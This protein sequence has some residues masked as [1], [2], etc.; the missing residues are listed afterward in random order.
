MSAMIPS[1]H[2]ITLPALFGWTPALLISKP[3]AASA[4][5][6]A[7]FLRSDGWNAAFE[8]LTPE[9]HP[10]RLEP[11]LL[12][13][14]YSE[15]DLGQEW[16]PTCQDA[17]TLGL[18]RRATWQGQHVLR[19]PSSRTQDATRLPSPA[20]APSGGG[21]AA[22][23]DR[24]RRRDLVPV[25]SAAACGR[26]G[27]PLPRP[28]TSPRP[29]WSAVASSA[30]GRTPL[31]P[32]RNPCLRCRPT[33]ARVLAHSQPRSSPFAGRKSA[34]IVTGLRTPE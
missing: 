23:R 12:S 29:R 4:R 8:D 13:R 34:W 30:Y 1:G 2:F 19:R 10:A 17:V 32:G 7:G 6:G 27:T 25:S 16:M 26:R 3:R 18:P 14:R 9:A 31:C 21:P 11:I 22:S 33:R 28:C 24:V 5:T 20:K 15:G